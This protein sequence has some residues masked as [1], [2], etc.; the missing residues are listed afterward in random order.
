[1]RSI[2]CS[3]ESLVDIMNVYVFYQHSCLVVLVQ[4]RS[5]LQRFPVA[6]VILVNRQRSP[7]CD[8]L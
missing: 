3:S 5:F 2:F 6:F 7:I 4:Q 1:M 8:V